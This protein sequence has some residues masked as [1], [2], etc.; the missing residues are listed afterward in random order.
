MKTDTIKYTIGACF[1][2]LLTILF[3]VHSEAVEWDYQMSIQFSFDTESPDIPEV[4]GYR[5][6]RDGIQFCE[7]IQPA[8]QEITCSVD[9]PGTFDFT[10]AAVYVNGRQSPQ[11][12]PFR[13]SVTS[14]DAALVALQ[15]LSGQDP[16]DI[17]TVG[18]LAGTPV[19]EMADIIHSL[20]QSVQ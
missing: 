8:S 16:Q 5:L 9:T 17:E 15:V 13:F 6:Y 1:I 18:S 7:V 4:V 3:P 20:R 19:I 11:S 10:M 14:E 2:S 12:A